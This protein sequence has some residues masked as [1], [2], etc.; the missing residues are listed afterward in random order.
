MNVKKSTSQRREFEVSYTTKTRLLLPIHFLL[1]L[2]DSTIL[3]VYYSLKL[4]LSEFRYEFKAEWQDVWKY[5]FYRR[6]WRPARYGSVYDL[7]K[8]E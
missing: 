3:N 6:C 4:A 7:P 1:A 8:E 2:L 5:T